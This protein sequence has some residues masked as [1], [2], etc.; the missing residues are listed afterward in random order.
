[1]RSLHSQ[2]RELMAC[3]SDWLMIDGKLN[4]RALPALYAPGMAEEVITVLHGTAY[5]PI[6]ASGPI[7]ARVN[8]ESELHG[9]W[10]AN[11]APA[12]HAWRFATELPADELV[13]Y[14]R[15]RLLVN[16]PLGRTL[17][18]RY[19]D[20][21]VLVRGIE[22][23]VFPADFW[24]GISALLPS[25]RYGEWAPQIESESRRQPWKEPLED[26]MQPLFTFDERQLA[27]LSPV[28][29]AA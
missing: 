27:L 10:A 7:L 17:W 26:R 3:S 24:H 28:E 13:A 6:A 11:E 21:R 15:R 1:M 18:L 29:T 19:A 9:R 12:C 20:S 8:T 14:W 23:D 4:P 25:L 16:G 22:H 5:E 2:G